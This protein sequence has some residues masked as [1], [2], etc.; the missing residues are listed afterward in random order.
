[1]FHGGRCD[2]VS[3]EHRKQLV[4]CSI[5]ILSHAKRDIQIHVRP[6]KPLGALVVV[7]AG[8][9]GLGDHPGRRGQRRMRRGS[10]TRGAATAPFCE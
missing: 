7:P 4:S 6:E 1:M 10:E 2:V 3:R 5:S 9:E 8:S